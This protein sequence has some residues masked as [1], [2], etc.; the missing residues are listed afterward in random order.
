M[1]SL[2]DDRFGHLCISVRMRE[3]IFVDFRRKYSRGVFVRRHLL[4]LV[5]RA[6]RVTDAAYVTLKKRQEAV[7][8]HEPRRKLAG[9]IV[10][11]IDIIPDGVEQQKDRDRPEEDQPEDSL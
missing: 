2:N 11:R 6:A 10:L 5:E 3:K 8:R 7:V 1:I 4:V 9:G